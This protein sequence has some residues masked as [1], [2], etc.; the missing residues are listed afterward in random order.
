M[1]IRRRRFANDQTGFAVIDAE[2]DGGEIVLVGVLSHLEERERVRIRGVWQEDKRFGLQVKVSLAEPVAPTGDVAL[3]AYLKR[4]KH[5]GATRADKLL[6]RYGDGVLEAI[7]QDPQA[8]FRVAGLNP[9]RTNEAIKS[10]HA[11]R[12]TRQLHLLLAPHGLAWLVP[13]IANQYGDHAHEV[14]RRRPYEL[15]M[16]FGIGF[17]IADTIAGRVDS[18]AR[19][20]AGVIHVLAEA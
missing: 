12:S 18:P 1:A 9:R 14:V 17:Q 6:A 10:W 19:N 13:R 5:I 2:R 7:D 3:R 4:V 15:T 16:V 11:L 8:A 20:K